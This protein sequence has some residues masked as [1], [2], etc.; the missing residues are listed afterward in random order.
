LFDIFNIHAS[1]VLIIKEKTFQI[2]ERSCVFL[3]ENLFIIEIYIVTS[4]QIVI[5][6]ILFFT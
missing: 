6:I 5:H 2:I 1:K 4:V 3:K